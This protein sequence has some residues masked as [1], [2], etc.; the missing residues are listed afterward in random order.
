MV[1]IA[2]AVLLGFVANEWR[3]EHNAQ[4]SAQEALNHISEEVRSNQ[5]Q[6][7]NRSLYYASMMAA[8]DSLGRGTL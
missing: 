4:R 3:E 1:S 6:L 7:S 2:L 8:I 5:V